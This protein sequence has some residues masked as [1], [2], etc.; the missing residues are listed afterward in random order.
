M[1]LMSKKHQKDRKLKNLNKVERH[2]IRKESIQNS[3]KIETEDLI[4]ENKKN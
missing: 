3:A 2:K 1:K 4:I